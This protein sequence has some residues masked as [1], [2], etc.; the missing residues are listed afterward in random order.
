MYENVL[1]RIGSPAIREEAVESRQLF[2]VRWLEVVLP[3]GT[4][5]IGTLRISPSTKS[6]TALYTKASY[7]IEKIGRGERILTSDPC[8]RTD[9]SSYGNVWNFIVRNWLILESIVGRSLRLV[10]RW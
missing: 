5:R 7:L 9:S 8:S 3:G 2:F 6:T 10:G 4:A 1:L